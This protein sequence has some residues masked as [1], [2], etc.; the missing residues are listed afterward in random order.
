MTD[1]GF[2]RYFFRRLRSKKG[3]TTTEYLMVIAV[4]SIAVAGFFIWNQFGYNKKAHNAA[5][6]LATD[7]AEEM[8]GAGVE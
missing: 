5:K 1:V 7:L 8:T 3:Q 6:V 4:I 2:F